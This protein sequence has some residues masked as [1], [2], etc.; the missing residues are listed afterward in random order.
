MVSTFAAVKQQQRE[1]LRDF[2]RT[3][4]ARVTPGEVGLV[5]TGARRTPGLRREEVALLAGV[6]VSWYTW[7]EQ[8]RDINVS[9]DI[10][11][12]VSRALRLTEPERAHLF[13]LAGP[14]RPQPGVPAATVAPELRELLDS[15]GPRPAGLRDR[16]WN[17]LAVNAGTRWVFGHDEGDF[18]CLISFFTNPRFRELHSEWSAVAPDMV[19]AFRADAAHTPGDPAFERMITELRD[20]SAEFD[21]L[22][23]RHDVAA[24]T[25]A[26]KTIRHPEAGELTFDKTT[27]AVIDQPD[28]FLEL[29]NPRAGTG[30]GERLDRLAQ[31]MRVTVG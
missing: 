29:Y 19:A 10:L 27:L 12:A 28:W 6:G 22:W 15:W 14:P 7:L 13:L 23:D 9:E 8:G 31:D 25:R 11:D 21:E 24:P 5:T 3:R 1:Q 16:H 30:T 17:L 20:A 26:V 18:N 4:R 2:L